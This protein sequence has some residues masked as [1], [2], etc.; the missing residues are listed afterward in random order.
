MMVFISFHWLF[1]GVEEEKTRKKREGKGRDCE[2]SS[3]FSLPVK[4]TIY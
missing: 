4:S 3:T 2:K 1:E